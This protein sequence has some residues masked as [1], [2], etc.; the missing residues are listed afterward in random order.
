MIRA[1]EIVRALGGRW[2]QDRG[3]CRCPAHEDHN[4]SLSMTQHNG[5]VL[6]HCHAGCP[7]DAVLDALAAQGLDIRCFDEV[8]SGDPIGDYRHPELGK[9]S[10][11]WPYVDA[12]G[13]LIGYMARFETE[14]GKQFRPLVLIDGRWRAQGLPEPRPLF[15]LPAI[16]ERQDA[17]VLVCEGEKAAEAASKRFPQ[18]V[19]TTSMHGAK[20]PRKTD[21]SPLKDRSVTVWPDHDKAG[22]DFAKKVAKLAQDA[23]AASVRV[24]KL[25][26][27][28]PEGWDLAD[29]PPTALDLYKLLADAPE[30]EASDADSPDEF[31][32]TV[33]RLAAL[34]PHEYDRCREKEAKRLDVRLK[35]LDDAVEAARKEPK[36]NDGL[37]GRAIEWPE[38]EPWPK[39]VDGVALLTD[40]SSLIGCYVSMPVHVADAVALW[41]VATWLHEHLDVSTFLNVTSATKRCGK[42]LLFEVIAE[43]VY[44]PLP[45]SGGVSPAA[46]FRTIEKCSP[47][48]LLDEADTYFANDLELR[49]V[50][51]GSQRRKLAFVPRC[52]G[53]DH[54]PRCFTTWCPKAMS[55]IG[56]LPDTV[57][58]RCVTVR[59]ERRP[60]GLVLPHWSERDKAVIE[61]LRRRIARWVDEETAT[62]LKECRRINFPDGLH[63]RARDAW[64]ILLAIGAVA[65][66]EWAGPEGR[67]RRVCEHVNANV[68][69][70]TGDREKLLADLCEVFRNSGDPDVLA[71]KEILEAL[72]A[73]E[74]RPWSEW[75]HDKP[76]S[77]RGLATLLK[78]FTVRPTTFRQPHSGTQKG[79][80]R[81]Q[82]E[83]V[84]RAYLQ[85]RG[86]PSGTPEQSN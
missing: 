3:M 33:I 34:L 25:P 17:L 9:A 11:T 72:H 37:Q 65:G 41:S 44:R 39:P 62:I 66:G 75:K 61:Q 56:N 32:Q 82:L 84:W 53:E 4:P 78:P 35:T 10:H 28:L 47:T 7:Q 43:L 24:V 67:A 83:P 31:D 60:P 8:N 64:R 36:G 77:P 52:V 42:S 38:M 27:V 80:R 70:E 20:S 85:E 29:D 16:L 69:G 73:M 55:G 26:D 45:L 71:T 22:V 46:L 50:V 74:G 6:V 86:S 23:G 59:L 49:G 68:D 1:E 76:L 13:K 57:I 2:N 12:T 14:D 19:A 30:C 54:E 15:N 51:N 79:Y 58:D 63:D 81:E 40:L 5:R 18:F 21:W 48:L